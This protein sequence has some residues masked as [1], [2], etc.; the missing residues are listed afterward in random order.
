MKKL[1]VLLVIVCLMLTA[2]K[3]KEVVSQQETL[4]DSQTT[5]VEHN[6]S[7]VQIPVITEADVL[8]IRK[9]ANQ[10]ENDV[11]VSSDSWSCGENDEGKIAIPHEPDTQFDIYYM[12]EKFDTK[13]KVINYLTTALTVMNAQEQI[14]SRTDSGLFAEINGA[15]GIAPWEGVDGTDWD[16]AKVIDFAVGDQS[17]DAVIQVF[18]AADDS[19]D[20]YEGHYIYEDGWKEDSF[21]IR[22]TDV[23]VQNEPALPNEGNKSE[24]VLMDTLKGTVKVPRGLLSFLND[25]DDDKDNSLIQIL[26]KDMDQDGNVEYVVSFGPDKE[27]YDTNYVIRD[28]QSNY[29]L[30]K[31]EIQSGGYYIYDISL[32]NLESSRQSYIYTGITNGAFLEGVG[33]YGISDS[34]VIQLYYGASATGS[35]EDLVEDGN[36]DGTFDKA[37]AYRHFSRFERISTSNWNGQNFDEPVDSFKND[38]SGFVYPKSTEDLIE[39]YIEA[40]FLG[41]KEETNQMTSLEM[42]SDFDILSVFEDTSEFY[43]FMAFDDVEYKVIKADKETKI[44]TMTKEDVTVQFTLNFDSTDQRW[45]IA[46]I[47]EAS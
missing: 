47:E 36:N 8:I 20:T 7:E 11:F 22:T 29:Q 18:D 16:T 33:V 40:V 15:T 39:T 38:E 24:L 43:Y 9:K 37:V 27:T 42:V 30:L 6:N 32:I 4:E 41:A 44:M 46:S 10:V 17:V 1:I 35:G 31:P 25:L 19:Y 5:Q 12:C 23:G 21:N 3:D 28:T 14:R 2:C 13:D 26:S 45:M 34:E